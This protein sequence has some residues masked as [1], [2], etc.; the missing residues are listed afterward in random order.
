MWKWCWTGWTMDWNFIQWIFS[1]F[2]EGQFSFSDDPWF[3]KANSVPSTVRCPPCRTRGKMERRLTALQMWLQTEG[4]CLNSCLCPF[5]GFL[6][7]PRVNEWG[8][9]RQQVQT[10]WCSRSISNSSFDLVTFQQHSLTL[11]VVYDKCREQLCSHEALRGICDHFHS[12]VHFSHP[13]FQA[14][15]HLSPT[16]LPGKNP[17]TL[18][19]PE[20]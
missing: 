3:W 18:N 10:Q 15:S 13:T 1:W 14:R 6:R 9:L 4:T 20:V 16:P 8:V 5:S 12:S 19:L 2:P 17:G 11:P 7:K